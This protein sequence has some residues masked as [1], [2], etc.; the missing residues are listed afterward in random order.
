MAMLVFAG[1]KK[2][3]KT[4]VPA[5]HVAATLQAQT[6]EPEPS[7]YI[8]KQEWG[9]EC[10][11][12]RFLDSTIHPFGWAVFFCMVCRL[13]SWI[14]G[15]DFAR[16][17]WHMFVSFKKIKCW[18]LRRRLTCRLAACQQKQSMINDD[19]IAKI[20]RSSLYKISRRNRWRYIQLGPLE[21]LGI[22]TVES[23]WGDVAFALWLQFALPAINPLAM[24]APQSFPQGKRGSR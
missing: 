6:D 2:I 12:L 16:L 18:L 14:P 24:R 15:I 8:Y 20:S 23:N 10:H 3:E 11:V 17:P 19:R 21:K 1:I 22:W 5:T 7:K 9:L 13:T 4:R